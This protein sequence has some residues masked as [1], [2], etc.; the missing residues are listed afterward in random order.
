MQILF[1]SRGGYRFKLNRVDQNTFSI[2]PVFGREIGDEETKLDGEEE[3]N[4]LISLIKG[5]RETMN[6]VYQMID[7]SQLELLLDNGILK[8]IKAVQKK[9]QSKEE[10]NIDPVKVSSK[11]GLLSVRMR[12]D[13]FAKFK[14][15]NLYMVKHICENTMQLDIEFLKYVEIGP[16][17]IFLFVSLGI[18]VPQMCNKVPI[19]LSELQITSNSEKVKQLR[20]C[21]VCLLKFCR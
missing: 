4:Y 3:V 8:V 7:R 2:I 21:C 19:C 14:D 12:R 17:P 18:P 11:Q 5:G 20:D 10:L 16:E 15:S 1:N 9:M 13:E 6:G